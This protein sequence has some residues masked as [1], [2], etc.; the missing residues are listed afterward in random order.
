MRNS[1]EASVAE[2]NE[3]GRRVVGDKIREAAGG[4]A[5]MC[6]GRQTLEHYSR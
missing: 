6:P 4:I 1:E 3:Q 5:H 2:Q